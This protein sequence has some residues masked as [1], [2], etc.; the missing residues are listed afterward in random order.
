MVSDS[1]IE[2]LSSEMSVTS[3]GEHLEHTVIEG[4][5]GHIKGT[6]TEIEDKNILLIIF[7]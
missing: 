1:L 3:S 2:D 7:V 4:K 5:D 6:T